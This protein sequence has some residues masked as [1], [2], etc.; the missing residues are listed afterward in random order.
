ML[1]VT[2]SVQDADVI[3]G[4][5]RVEGV[6]V[7]RYPTGFEVRLERVLKLRSEGLRGEEEA[8]RTAARDMLRYGSYKPTGRGKPASEYLLRAASESQYTFP[9]I[10]GPVDACNLMS[11]ERVVPISLWDLDRAGT[12]SFVFRHGRAGENYVFN[13]GGQ[14]IDVEDLLV[15]CRVEEGGD[16]GGEPIVNPVRDSLATKT[17]PETHR[18]AAC[19]YA[20]AAAFSKADVGS[21]AREFANLLAG[22][23]SKVEAGAGVL[24]SLDAI[25]V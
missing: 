12:Q 24:A 9:R 1:S 11:L 13:Q 21:M 25:H 14:R 2:L 5:V 4:V 19:I 18:I 23:G 17:T 16:P 15:G 20:P 6:A 10:N 7:D 22:C 3:L 8:R